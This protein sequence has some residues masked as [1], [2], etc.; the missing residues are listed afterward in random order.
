MFETEQKKINETIQQ[1]TTYKAALEK[2]K[3]NEE[4]DLY[5]QKL[6]RA[7]WALRTTAEMLLS[8]LPS[9]KKQDM[10]V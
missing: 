8:T 1:L 4:F 10:V 3:E 2:A 9:T 5:N 7:V 6:L